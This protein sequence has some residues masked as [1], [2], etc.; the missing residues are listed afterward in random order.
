M[1][2]ATWTISRPQNTSPEEFIRSLGGQ[3]SGAIVLDSDL[4]LGY[5]SDDIQIEGLTQW[6]VVIKSQEQAL[7]L[8][9]EL[10]SECFLDE[11]GTIRAPI[12]N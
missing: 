12:N 7:A 9:C 1:K 5:L 11:D 2:Y 10:N 6:N 8:A 3:A 4:I